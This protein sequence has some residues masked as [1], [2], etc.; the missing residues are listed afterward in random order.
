MLFNKHVIKVSS[1]EILPS[2]DILNEAVFIPE[3]D[4]FSVNFMTS[5]YES[6]LIL[7]NLGTINFLIVFHIA[8]LVISLP[9][10]ILSR[11]KPIKKI[12][13]K[14]KK[15]L[16]WNAFIRLFM[17]SYLD[18]ILFSILEI[19]ESPD[20]DSRFF[21][22]RLSSGIALTFLILCSMLPLIFGIIFGL[23]A[24]KWT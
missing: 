19:S 17:A 5:G 8:L 23:K 14:L 24:S 22:I 10:W 3:G 20:F 16:L 13:D 7:L 15:Y 9:L 21:S 11:C 1:F 4:P 2:E 12:L 18:L 6:L